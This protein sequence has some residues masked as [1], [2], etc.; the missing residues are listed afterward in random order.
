MCVSAV[1]SYYAEV[2]EPEQPL[3]LEDLKLMVH[4][5]QYHLWQHLTSFLGM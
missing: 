3:R 5:S 4:L 2:R 1:C